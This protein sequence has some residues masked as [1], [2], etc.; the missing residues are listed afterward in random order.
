MTPRMLRIVSLVAFAAAA[1]AADPGAPP[2]GKVQF[3]T[4]DR[5]V[6][7]EVVDWGG[8]GRPVILLAGLGATAHA[9]DSFAPKL[10]AHCHVFGIT[11]RGFGASDAPSAGYSSDRLGDDVLAVMDALRII[12]PVLVGH[13]MAGEELSSIGSRYPERV[14]GLVYL[15]AAYSYAFYDP[16]RGD[17]T[18][19]SIELRDKIDR[20]LRRDDPD[21]R[22]LI[23]D[24]LQSV[25]RLERELQDLQRQ[26]P[27]MP[28]PQKEAAAPPAAPAPAQLIFEGWR[29][30]TSVKAPVLAI[31]ADPHAFVGLFENDPAGRAKAEAD[32][33]VNAEAQAKVIESEAPSSRIVRMAHAT[34]MIYESREADV[35][36]EVG[37]FLEGL[38]GP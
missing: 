18:I 3:V 35:L 22:P 34:H 8:S 30:Y 27:G 9:F 21:P 13:S 31:L 33:V 2:A 11:R 29:K 24:L 38:P 32:D 25:P 7:L 36:R 26:M 10:A 37:A 5:D 17:L 4:V 1:R 20:L 19:D 16:S 28:G 14:A 23:A 15:E 12:K 6:K